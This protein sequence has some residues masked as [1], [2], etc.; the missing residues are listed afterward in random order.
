M[1]PGMHKG[2]N[3]FFHLFFFSAFVTSLRLGG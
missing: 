1:T 2:H 3:A